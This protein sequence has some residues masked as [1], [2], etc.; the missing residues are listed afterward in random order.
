M[1]KRLMIAIVALAATAAEAQTLKIATLAPE[2]TV[3]MK[4]MRAAGA[5]IKS[6]TAGRVEVKFFPGGVMGNDTAVLRK[7]KLGQLQGGALSGA[8]LSPIYRD[9]SI[10]SL[11]FIFNDLAEVDYVR[12][13]IDPLLRAGFEKSGLVAVGLSGGGFAYLMS[14]KPIANKDDLRATKVWVPQNDRIAQ[15]AFEKAGVNPIALPLGDVNTSLQTGLLETVGITTSGAIAF[16]WHTKVKHAVDLPLTYV[17][18]VLAIDQKAFNRV[19]AADQ[20]IV[21][22]EFAKAFAELDAAGKRDNESARA[23]LTKLGIVFKVPSADEIGY[24]H[25]IGEQTLKQ[26]LA[27][28]EISKELL[29]AILQARA[30]YRAKTAPA[31]GAK[32]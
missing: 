10:Y 26:M 23:A 9:A 7:I 12:G 20:P 15:V 13:K 2:G 4:E 25:G 11:P 22:E 27:N 17:I 24:W 14:T 21:R 3:W 1:L 31:A 19:T 8:E 6:R 29:D 32:P 5:S 28:N 16:Q 18:G 30:E